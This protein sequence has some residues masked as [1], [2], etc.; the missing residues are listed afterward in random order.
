M[1]VQLHTDFSLRV[2]VDTRRAAWVPSP[3]PGVERIMLERDGGEQ[4]RATSVVRYA[5]GTHF[6]PHVHGRGEE[7]LVLDGEFR[8]EHGVYPAGT[9]VRN[10]W[11]SQH[12]PYSD[13]GCTLFAKLRQVAD[14]EVG[15]VCVERAVERCA[16][17]EVLLYAAPTE[18][19][20]MWRWEPGRIIAEPPVGIG[21][22]TN[23]SRNINININIEELLVLDGSFDDELGHHPVGTW[24]RRP[25]GGSYHAHSDGGCLLFVKRSRAPT[26]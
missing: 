4:A 17:G 24:L 19:A 16:V 10:P 13:I 15:R 5:A 11:G 25:L 2:V 23:T 18:W 7:F 20:A 6:M 8:D 1:E 3:E 9:Y 26:S 12:A 14:G 22:N 21:R